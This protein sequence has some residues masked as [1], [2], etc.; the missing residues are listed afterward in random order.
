M[1]LSFEG[2][3]GGYVLVAHELEQL[4]QLFRGLRHSAFDYRRWREQGSSSEK[5]AD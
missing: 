1:Q 4:F 5:W 2:S 3:Q